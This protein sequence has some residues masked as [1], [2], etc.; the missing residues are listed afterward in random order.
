VLIDV[1][2]TDRSP[3]IAKLTADEVGRQLPRFV[4]ELE[5][6]RRRKARR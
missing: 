2:V 4:N 5:S 3:R 1:G 6:S